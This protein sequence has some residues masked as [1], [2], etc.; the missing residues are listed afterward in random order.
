M[1]IFKNAH[2]ITPNHQ[3][4]NQCSARDGIVDDVTNER[5]TIFHFKGMQMVPQAV[6][7]LELSINEP[8]RWL[9]LGDLAAPA[10]RN[11]MQFQA[12]IDRRSGKH[13]DGTRREHLKI[14]EGGGEILKPVGICKELKHLV[15]RTRQ[16]LFG[17]EP[18]G[19]A[20][21]WVRRNR[22]QFHRAF[23]K[24]LATCDGDFPG[25]SLSWHTPKNK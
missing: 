5:A 12:V 20:L 3:P 16:P 15:K 22:D 10:D 18:I 23:R 2:Q 19:A 1:S 8:K 25:N 13:V 11:P 14:Q 21:S 17:A 24:R 9:P 7:A 6:R 4:V